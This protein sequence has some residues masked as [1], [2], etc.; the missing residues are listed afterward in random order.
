MKIR[1]LILPAVAIV[2]CCAI[3]SSMA[4]GGVTID[5]VP[6]LAP[7]GFGS[8]SYG[9]WVANATY[10]IEN[11][12]SSYGPSG[13]DQY[14]AVSGPLS[15]SDIFVTSFNSWL[16][17]ANPG[18]VFGPAYANELGNRLLFGLHIVADE[19][20]QF[21]ISQLSFVGTSTDPDNALGFG[22]A[23]GSYNYS[24]QYLGINYGGDGVKG[25]GDDLLITGGANTQLIN[26]L[27]GRG[28][29]N[30]YWPSTP[31]DL[32]TD[33]AWL[34]ENYGDTE[35]TGIYSLG[36][37]TGSATVLLDSPT[38]QPVPEPATFVG[39][40]ALAAIIGLRLRRK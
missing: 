36:N 13:P 37:F 23:A 25:G 35:F 34:N 21:S 16:G 2:A 14:N 9:S 27:V 8:P 18:D 15:Y 32:A 4:Q 29:G 5:V 6:A 24:T 7:N 39:G 12:L 11:G 1:Q 20:Q 28:S 38:D 31:A 30:A 26:E 19:G 10:A 3:Q 40:L 17:Q 33:L 22:F